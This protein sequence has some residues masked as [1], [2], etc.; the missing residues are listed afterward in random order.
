M[1]EF[2]LCEGLELS[3]STTAD[4]AAAARCLGEKYEVILEPV[5]GAVSLEIFAS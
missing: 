2:Y 1:K 3:E 4:A 5:F